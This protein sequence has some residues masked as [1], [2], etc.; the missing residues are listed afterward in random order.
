MVAHISNFPCENAA[1]PELVLYELHPISQWCLSP[2]SGQ[3]PITTKT[4]I[5][6]EVHVIYHLSTV[7]ISQL[8]R[9]CPLAVNSFTSSLLLA[10]H[11]DLFIR[12]KEQ[13]K[14]ANAQHCFLFMYTFITRS[15]TF[16]SF[17]GRKLTQTMFPS[18]FPWHCYKMTYLKHC[19][20][21]FMHSWW[22]IT[23]IMIRSRALVAANVGRI[24]RGGCGNINFN[25]MHG[26]CDWFFS[27]HL[28]LLTAWALT[29]SWLSHLIHSQWH[30]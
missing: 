25:V 9:S 1:L 14:S 29:S 8:L 28:I 22:V 17:V 6:T 4:V 3:I 21:I 11:S 19:G 13:P 15:T 18:L 2:G 16:I 10:R 24:L 30:L 23:G 27:Y 26:Y 5:L 20:V 12:K 7:P